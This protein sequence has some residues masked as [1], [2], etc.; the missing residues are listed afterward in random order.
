MKKIGILGGTFNPPHT[1]HFLMALYA[2]SELNLDEVLF[3]PA[4]TVPHKDNSVIV[5]T[6]LRIEMLES[7]L[8]HY[9]Y[10][11]ICS[12]EAAK[13]DPGYTYETLRELKKLYPEDELYFIVGADS[14]AYMDKWR[15][16]QKIF[17][18]A[19]IAAACRSGISSDEFRR[20][21]KELRER[22]GAEIVYLNMPLA[23]FSSTEIRRRVRCGEPVDFMVPPEIVD[24]IRKHELYR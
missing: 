11:N 19:V 24:Y 5:P 20:K 12:I 21:G 2:H 13:S 18:N 7:V 1:G 22:F 9:P 6:Q 14:L 16:P 17:D 3:L 10:F 8:R 23:D 15:E 4:G